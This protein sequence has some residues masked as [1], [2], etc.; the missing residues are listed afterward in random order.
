MMAASVFLPMALADDT[1]AP[2]TLEK[3]QTTTRTATATTAPASQPSDREIELREGR[4]IIEETAAVYRNCKSYQ[5]EGEVI[6]IDDLRSGRR[7]TH[8][9]FKTAFVRQDRFRFED[10]DLA[11]S[12]GQSIIYCNKADVRTQWP[13]RSGEMKHDSRAIAIAA[14]WWNT[15]ANVF[16]LAALL[17]PDEFDGV[18]YTRLKNVR[19]SD[20]E[21]SRGVQY[22]ILDA[23]DDP[24]T[25]IRIWIDVDTKLVCKVIERNTFP[26]WPTEQTTTYKPKINVDIPAQDLEFDPPTK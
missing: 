14:T 16:N 22:N 15:G 9:S 20:Q 21:K 12:P 5:D 17:L 6:R 4:R 24:L 8:R 3:T 13:D 11:R 23:D 2:A 7:T 10:R 19:F 26:R 25:S 18:N 1:K